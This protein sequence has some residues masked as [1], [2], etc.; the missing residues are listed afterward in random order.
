MAGSSSEMVWMAGYRA[1]VVEPEERVSRLIRACL[2]RAGM[3]VACTPGVSA[4]VE[5]LGEEV[6]GLPQVL[7]VEESAGR[8]RLTQ[9]LR[10]AARAIPVVWLVGEESRSA[11]TCGLQEVCV[12]RI[13]KPFSPPG[14]V[15]TIRTLLA[16]RYGWVVRQGEVKRFA[17]VAVDLCCGSGFSTCMA[18]EGEGEDT[19]VI[20]LDRDPEALITAR[21]RVRLI[22]YGNIR[23]VGAEAACLPFR[24]GSVAEVYGVGDLPRCARPA[25]RVAEA[26]QEARRIRVTPSKA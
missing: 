16:V 6:A 2:E 10:S 1:L 14:L 23:F 11:C 19:L 8:E 13:A 9:Q 18:A 7:I 3:E 12:C 15:I 4:A 17:R 5:V 20:G 26:M 22:G 21:K 25:E 24:D